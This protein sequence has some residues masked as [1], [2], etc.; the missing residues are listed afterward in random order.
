MLTNEKRV[1][2]QLGNFSCH[3]IIQVL[4]R[5]AIIIMS[6][7]NNNT[8]F[9]NNGGMGGK[10]I[11][12]NNENSK[13]A[14][15]GRCRWTVPLSW[16]SARVVPAWPGAVPTW[17]SA[18]STGTRSSTVSDPRT[19]GPGKMKNENTHWPSVHG[20]NKSAA[21]AGSL[22]RLR[23]PGKQARRRR[24]HQKVMA[25]HV[26]PLVHWFLG[27]VHVR[28]VCELFQKRS[29]STTYVPLDEHRVRPAAVFVDGHV[30]SSLGNKL[31]GYVVQ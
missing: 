24:T 4:P 28:A 10:K 15:T 21:R 1:S 13:C 2:S 22:G 3:Y 31:R 30:C 12:I 6:T 25:A 18:R 29:F 14:I 23:D 16:C 8:R 26:L 19:S 5:A 27:E 9:S 20:Y 17:S 7:T 11:M